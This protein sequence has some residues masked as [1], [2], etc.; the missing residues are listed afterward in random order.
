[1]EDS[2]NWIHKLDEVAETPR[3]YEHTANDQQRKSLSDAFGLLTCDSFHTTYE[4]KA[5][6]GARVALVGRIQAE[7]TQAC[8]VTLESVPFQVDENVD[9]T[10]VP[11][12]SQ[13][14][15]DPDVEHEALALQD[16]EPYS[17]SELNVGHVLFDLFGATLDPYPRA[18]G[19]SLGGPIGADPDQD[20][21]TH[22]FAE[23]KKLKSQS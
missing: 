17:G 6:S 15:E 1:V 8:V 14:P 10:F 4:L 11:A 20:Q 2:L 5:I 9:V 16:V 18:P 7:G 3:S 19:A 21:T 13:E 23:L 12:K 22:P